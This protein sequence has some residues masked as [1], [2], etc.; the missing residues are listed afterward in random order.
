LH[1]K[2]ANQRDFQ[3][4]GMRRDTRTLPGILLG[5]LL[6][7][8]L[9]AC[10]DSS[11]TPVAALAA[12]APAPDQP[13]PYAVGRSSFTALDAARGNRSLAVE[14][15]Y[16]VDEADRLDGPLTSYELAPGI[17]LP[18][19]L[20]M[21]DLPVSGRPDQVLLVYSHGYGGINTASVALTETL[22]SHGFI[23]VSPE[24]TG[25]SQ[26]SGDDSFDEAAA[27]RVPDVSFLID[28]MFARS[29]D[30]DDMFYQRVSADRVGV[31]G[32][33]FGGMTAVGMASGWA[34]AEPDP[35][36]R[37]IVPMSAVIRAELQSDERSG[38]NAGFTPEQLARITIPVMLVGGTEDFDVFLENNRIAFA[39][40]TN[41]PAV[42]QLDIIG[43][44][45]THFA[46]V[47]DIGNLLLS[48]GLT[49]DLWPAVGAE[50]LLEPYAMTCTPDAFPIDEA[51]RLQN[52]Y[53]VSFFR[54]HLLDDDR[55]DAFLTPGFAD[56]E[57]AVN[58]SAK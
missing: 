51:F 48:L 21:D 55:Y 38:P 28:T 7:T 15:W 13:G 53:A 32:H 36:V 41:S 3:Y 11:D 50:D 33:S 29:R 2:V 49:Q 57:P 25:N 40:M 16:P 26:N 8:G 47:C 58:F 46:N 5:L 44:N 22:A 6:V 31:V 45:H 20:A 56:S 35:R 17:G 14:V 18:S 4:Q 1:I 30:P 39:E 27:R 9:V 42:Y 37:A 23:V 52:L 24:H 10:S 43:A 34:G 54:R 19:A 12:P